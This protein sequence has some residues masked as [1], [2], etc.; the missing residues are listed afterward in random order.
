M[1]VRQQEYFLL[2]W[3]SGK[4]RD[5]YESQIYSSIEPVLKQKIEQTKKQNKQNKTK[6]KKQKQKNKKPKN[7]KTK[8]PK[9][10]KTK[11]PK[12]PK[13]KKT[14]KQNP[15]LLLSPSSHFYLLLNKIIK[16]DLDE[17]P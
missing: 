17:A 10:Q 9:N 4:Q 12:K 7:Q 11:K 3:I 16:K 6:N 2:F 1:S 14:K 13:N 8:K 5:M 15:S